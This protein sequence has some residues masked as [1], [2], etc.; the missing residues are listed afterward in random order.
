MLV[1][2]ELYDGWFHNGPKKP[3]YNT[4]FE[5]AY[6]E[7]VKRFVKRDRN[8][9]SVI[10][11]STGNEI[12]D[13]MRSRA[14]KAQRKLVSYF[15]KFDPTRNVT[16]GV[17]IWSHENRDT[18]LKHYVA[19]LDVA[20]YNYAVD[21]Y[22]EDFNKYPNRLIL[23]SETFPSNMFDYLMKMEDYHYVIGDF[24]WTGFDYL[25][26]AGIG[27]LGFQDIVDYYPWTVAYCGDIDIC[28]FK[29]PQ[30]YYREIIWGT[31]ESKVAAFVKKPEPTFEDK[32]DSP[33]AFDDVYACWTWPGYEGKEMKVDVYSRCDKVALHLNGKRIGTQRT[34]RNNEYTASFKVPYRPGT[35]KASAYNGEEL[36]D[37]FSLQTVGEPAKLELTADR[38]SIHANGQ[39]LSYIVVK[40]VDK[41]GLRRP[42]DQK[43][44]EFGI[45]GPGEIAALGSSNP[46]S[47]ESFQQNKRTT[48]LG[49]CIAIVK[50][51]KN[52]GTITVTAKSK[53]LP[54]NQITIVSK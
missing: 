36:I 46:K 23:G 6:K 42:F 50:S 15:K 1:I 25:G 31:G 10:L 48:F 5:Q 35:L 17:N 14:W 51:T 16:N 54:D 4:T 33:W 45:S 27:W 43:L 52:K 38:D 47:V 49:R 8:H 34:N 11:W 39:D 12:M 2:D 21:Q 18:V 9:P 3:Y 40:V 7:E 28:G 44:V 53:G 24:V 22:E 41:N 30:S 13:K 37:T 32:K 26:E 20:A 19:P 29:R